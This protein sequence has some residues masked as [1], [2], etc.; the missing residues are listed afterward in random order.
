M[1]GNTSYS[2]VTIEPEHLSP[3]VFEND[4]SIPLDYHTSLNKHIMNSG[5]LPPGLRYS[6]PGF[7]VFERPPTKKLVQY[8]DFSVG[9]M[10][11]GTYNED[12]EDYDYLTK[13]DIESHSACYEVPIPWQIYMVSYSTSPT[14]M[15]AVTYVRM[16]F[17]NTPLNDPNTR[18][19]MPYINNFF[20]DGSMCN[21]MIDD[22]SEISRYPKS[23]EGVIAS[24]YD[25]IWNTGFNRDLY[26]CIDQTIS[27]CSRYANNSIIR[28][29]VTNKAMYPGN[30][31]RFYRIM[32]EQSIEDVT[33]M[34]WANPSYTQHYQRDVD[35]LY[36]YSSK[37]HQ[38]YYDLCGK[39]DPEDKYIDSSEHFFSV[40]G[41][42]ETI[43]KTY[44]D[45]IN[46]MFFDSSSTRFNYVPYHDLLKNVIPQLKTF[47]SYVN[48][49]VQYNSMT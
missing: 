10:T 22:Y 16:Y 13:D 18:L 1:Y 12:T 35:F 4:S 42:P 21:P 45:I 2:K 29:A 39:N 49:L 27:L 43:Q 11:E 47:D 23:L 37:Y 41:K 32:S 5:I 38:M 31:S 15:Y 46:H 7:L 17:S 6:I 8:I 19:Y 26:E 33:S 14:S 28:D 24:A 40:I 3:L 30:I 34:E 48:G 25:W 20:T 44:L 36:N 9:D